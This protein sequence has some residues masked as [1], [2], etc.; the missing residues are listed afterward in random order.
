M[1]EALQLLMRLQEL[2]SKIRMHD[3][4]EAS[5]PQE[6]E[7]IQ[8]EIDRRAEAFQREVEE[9]ETLEKER[10]QKERDLEAAAEQI[11]KIQ[12][13]LTEVKTNKEYQAF[14]TE[15]DHL[16]EKMDQYEVEIIERL[17]Q[18]DNLRGTLKGKERIYLEE[19]EK[20]ETQKTE[21]EEKLAHLPEDLKGLKARREDLEKKIPP[22]LL[23]RYR[24][25]LEKRAGIAVV[26][27]RNEICQGCHMNIPPQLYN[28]VQKCEQILTC[29]HCNR[30]LVPFE[31]TGKTS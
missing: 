26:F 23:K 5:F 1:K 7:K 19:K 8:A 4:Q 15:I 21:L 6:I 29:P 17:E 18:V 16:K 22:D 13:R 3:R 12:G 28:Q 11:K 31:E 10:R 30:I 2:E 20:L 14:L 9:I 24:T 25:L 27:A